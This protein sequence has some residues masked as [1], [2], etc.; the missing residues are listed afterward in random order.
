MRMAMLL[1]LIFISWKKPEQRIT[2][3]NNNTEIID[4][5]LSLSLSLSFYIHI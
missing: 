4:R 5:P 2:Q 3:Y 1:V